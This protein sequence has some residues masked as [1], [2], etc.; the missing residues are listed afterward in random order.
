MEEGPAGRLWAPLAAALRER[1]SGATYAAWVVPVIPALTEGTDGAKALTLRLPSA[2]AL[3]R[4]RRPPIAPAL[5]EAAAT[6]GLDVTLE[7][8]G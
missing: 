1:L 5:A 3:D 2:F 7:A 4:W 6:L 8:S